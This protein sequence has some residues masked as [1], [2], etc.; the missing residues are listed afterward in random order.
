MN[1]LGH[2]FPS[3]DTPGSLA[4]RLCGAWPGSIDAKLACTG[5]AAEPDSLPCDVEPPEPEVWR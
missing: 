2:D 1:R 3:F 5:S 4:C